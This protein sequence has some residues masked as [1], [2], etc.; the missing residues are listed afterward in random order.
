MAD[1]PRTAGAPARRLAWRDGWDAARVS[2][3]TIFLLD[4]LTFGVWVA[5]LPLIKRGLDLSDLSFAAAL[6]GLVGGAFVAQPLSGMLAT[7]FGSRRIT[8]VAS[9]LSGLALSLPPF[10]PSLGVLVATTALLGFVR[11]CT[12]VPMNAQA[13]LLEARHGR[14]RMSSF[15]AAFS[16][17][18]SLGAGVGALFLR[19]GAG[20]RLTMPLVGLT[21]AVIAALVGRSLLHDSPRA[22]RP[23][24]EPATAALPHESSVHVLRDVPL[25]LL[26]LLAFCGLFGEGARSDWSALLLER[27]TGVAPA[28][29]ALGYAAFSVAM[30]SGRIAGDTVI[31]QFG[32]LRTLRVS[33]L[34][35]AG[36]LVI[37]ATAPYA[38]ALVGF[39]V[40]GFGYANLV[41]VLFGASGRR[42]GSA[43]V[44]AVSTIGYF[45]FVIGP[46][47]I[48]GLSQLFG[49]LPLALGIVGVFALII[50]AGAGVV[51]AADAPRVAAR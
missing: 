28:A 48:G 10:A 36:G 23:G 16:L 34:L 40:V 24:A 41:P 42:A 51:G 7:R 14:P 39:A 20:A 35:A 43:G 11:G 46:P 29:A 44:A 45:G 25:L 31:G 37:A 5:H 26:G 8:R 17:G 19:A 15:H 47:M 13:A 33:G 22:P 21:A 4:G 2:I 18:G 27:T 30:T 9:V 50:A 12:E 38:L 3:A 49:S 32:R 6:A 1:R